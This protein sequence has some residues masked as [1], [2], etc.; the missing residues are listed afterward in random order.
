LTAVFEAQRAGIATTVLEKDPVYVGGISRTV[1][2][3]GYRF[4]IGEHRFF[5]KSE[6]I[7]RWWKER[8]PDDFIQVRRMSRIF[9]RRKYFD[10]PLKPWNALSNLGFFTSVA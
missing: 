2:S 10:Y 1:Q 8:L 7:T 3:N 6:E 4:D 5:S 9:Y